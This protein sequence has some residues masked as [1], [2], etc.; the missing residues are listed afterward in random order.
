MYFLV[1]MFDETEKLIALNQFVIF[2]VGSGGFGGKK[3]SEQQR[4]ALPPPKRK[5]DQVCRETTTIDQAALYRLTGDE[6]PLHI[7]PAFAS[8]AGIV[9]IIIYLHEYIK[10]FSKVFHVQFYM[11]YVHLVM[12]LDMFYIPMLMMIQ[13][14]LKLLK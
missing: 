6:N 2:S 5:A 14:Y 1:E 4:K 13:H 10:V 11:V 9:K 3:V 7:D 8:A 12:L